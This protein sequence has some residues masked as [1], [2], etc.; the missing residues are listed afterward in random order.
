LHLF[1]DGYLYIKIETKLS[2]NASRTLCKGFG[3]D[4][5]VDGVAHYEVRK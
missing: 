3:G 2:W 4:L 5:V 1:D